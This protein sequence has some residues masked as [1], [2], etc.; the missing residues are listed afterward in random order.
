MMQK[1]VRIRALALMA[2]AAL[3]FAGCPGTGSPSPSG[4]KR[5]LG[6]T[7][8]VGGQEVR[9]DIDEPNNRITLTLPT[10]TDVT[11]LAPVITLSDKAT[12]SPASGAA[13]DF[14]NPVTYRVTA[15]DG[16]TRDY[17]VTAVVVLPLADT[18]EAAETAL[19]GV[20]VST[21]ESDVPEGTAWV[22][23]E[24]KATLDAALAEAEAMLA[25]P[26]ATEEEKEEAS[27]ALA[28]ALAAFNGAKG[29]GTK[30]EPVTET[31]KTALNAAITAAETAKTG[32]VV[33]TAA[34]NV[35]A[36]TNGLPRK[37]LIR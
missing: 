5:I 31:D 28:E 18:I 24:V 14:T 21:D 23:A 4:E 8:T 3:A 7:V 35:T 33:D 19:E 27:R 9:G 6:F 12:V 26:D 16:T 13:Q 10:G 34:G 32:V 37:R 29:T 11:A 36:G 25:D 2:I 15:E 22:S 30:E 20:A 1:H 17:T